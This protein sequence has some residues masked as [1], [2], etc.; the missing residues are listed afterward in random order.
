MLRVLDDANHD[1]NLPPMKFYSILNAAPG[2]YAGTMCPAP[3]T[4]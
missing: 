2:F 3:F 4:T 1:H